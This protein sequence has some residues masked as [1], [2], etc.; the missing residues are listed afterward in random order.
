MNNEDFQS[1]KSDKSNSNRYAFIE[2]GTQ[3]RKIGRIEVELYHDIVPRTVNNFM[4][5]IT[6]NKG[7]G[8]KKCLVHRIIPDFMIQMGDYERGNGSGGSSIYGKYFEDESF[9]LRHNEPGLLSM[10]NC[11]PNTNGSQF[12]ITLDYT[13]HL[14]GKHVVFGKVI[15]GMNIVKEV[16]KYGTVEGTPRDKVKIIDC[17]EM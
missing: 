1:D 15:K 2:F 13:P 3:N 7:V 11:G 16:E 5:L 12:F 17:G 6:G 10:A 8:Y 4:A 14:D 9:E